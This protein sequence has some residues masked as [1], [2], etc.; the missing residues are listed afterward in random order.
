MEQS[1]DM[2]HVSCRG[3]LAY[4]SWA[5][6]AGIMYSRVV[7][8]QDQYI[9]PQLEKLFD[10]A[11]SVS[12]D[13]FPCAQILFDPALDDDNYRSDNSSPRLRMEKD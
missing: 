1:F 4:I 11:W 13:H 10:V 2:I 5:M 9:L 6:R 7:I 8:A 3:N 12:R